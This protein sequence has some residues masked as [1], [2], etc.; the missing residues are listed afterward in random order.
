MPELW[1]YLH[2]PS[3]LL[4]SLLQQPSS[5]LDPALP[6]A[7]VDAEHRLLQLNARAR[8]AGLTTGSGLASAAALCH[9]LQLQPYDYSAETRLLQQL[10]LCLYQHC[11]DLAPD[12]PQGLWLRPGPMLQLYQG[13]SPW[14]QQLQQSVAPIAASLNFA[15]AQSAAAARLLARQGYNQCTAEPE[16]SW[17]ALR[18]L[19]LSVA[20]LPDQLAESLRRLGLKQLGQL[21]DLPRAELS[22]RFGPTLLHYLQQLQGEQPLALTP[23]RPQSN[24]SARLELWYEISDSPLLLAPANRL[25]RQLQQYLIERDLLAY[26]LQLVLTDREKQQ[27]QLSFSSVAGEQQS[28]AW[29]QL[30]GLKLDSLKLKAPV[31]SL[32]LSLLHAGPRYADQ[33]SL[34]AEHSARYSPA[35]L[36]SLLRARLG[37]HAV[38][39]PVLAN[40][41]VPEQA[42]Q[43]AQVQ[44][45]IPGK[46]SGAGQSLSAAETPNAALATAPLPSGWRPRLLH[47]TAQPL[48]SA[49]RALI[50]PQRLSCNWWQ[51][52]SVH[53]DYYVAQLASGQWAW[54]YQDLRQPGCWYQQG[55]FC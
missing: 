42:N 29:H 7:L 35:A 52:Q 43:L 23:L 30:L 49:P 12:P 17:P 37:E 5:A 41:L 11:A 21:L 20:G 19:P 31:I 50:G 13:F 39:Q 25:L 22:R 47:S 51:S 8:Q 38:R 14:W 44:Q 15:T 34:F 18:Q 3:L 4:D 16:Q 1:C 45:S 9:E 27:Q 46:G 6:C 26:Q 33:K 36:L 24:F 2:F 55:W 54:L 32:E 28:S 48:Q 53:R 40:H 10:A